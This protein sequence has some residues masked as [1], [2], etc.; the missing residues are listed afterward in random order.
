MQTRKQVH[1]VEQLFET[2]FG[3]LLREVWAN[4]KGLL[5]RSD[6]PAVIEY[7]PD[8]HVSALNLWY[9]NGLLHRERGAAIEEFDRRGRIRKQAWYKNDV[10]GRNDSR[11]KPGSF[12]YKSPGPALIEYD[13]ETQKRVYE[14]W[15]TLP[16]GKLHRRDGPAV[17]E[18]DPVTG[19]V[20]K[21]TWYASGR[22]INVRS[23][24]RSAFLERAAASRWYPNP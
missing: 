8:T 22:E 18:R 20:T 23:Q 14:E 17:I 24:T 12:R 19:V 7:H 4:R 6:G 15:R 10:C 21:A 5:D 3:E 2:R 13:V 11:L 1:S 9:R 16:D